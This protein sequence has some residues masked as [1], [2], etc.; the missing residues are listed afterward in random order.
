MLGAWGRNTSVSL[1]HDPGHQ[2]HSGLIEGVEEL[3]E[4]LA[5]LPQL[6][7]SDTKHNGK[8]HQAEDVHAILVR[9]NGHLWEMQTQGQTVRAQKSS[10]E[11]PKRATILVLTW[12]FAH[13]L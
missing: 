4:N 3:D 7:Q 8:H 11:K 9:C 10:S 12:W 5:L 6:P 2:H 1:P 13:L